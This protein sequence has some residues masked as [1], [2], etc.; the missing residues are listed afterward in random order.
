MFISLGDF[1]LG[2]NTI[3]NASVAVSY[4]DY[5]PIILRG[6]EVNLDLLR[7]FF[8]FLPIPSLPSAYIYSAYDYNYISGA[9]E[10]DYAYNIKRNNETSIYQTFE[11]PAFKPI[12]LVNVTCS[13][14]NGSCVVNT[15]NTLDN[16]NTYTYKLEIS[17]LTNSESNCHTVSN[18]ITWQ[19]H[20]N[21]I[22]VSN[23]YLKAQNCQYNANLKINK[24]IT[25]NHDR[26]TF[27]HIT[28]KISVNN[29]F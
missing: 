16:T 10:I 20:S 11:A 24:Q 13:Y 3:S 28:K 27:A 21:S 26:L 19:L 5:T 25:K 29:N 7:I 15:D 23:E 14:K 17:P 9:S 6:S 12:Q 22:N 4:K 18:D 2:K 8:W 1:G